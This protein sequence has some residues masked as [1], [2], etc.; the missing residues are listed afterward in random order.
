MELDRLDWWLARLETEIDTD[1][2]RA[3]PVAVKV[4]ERRARLLGL[5][6]PVRVEGTIQQVTAED[7]AL[8]ELIAEAQAAAAVAERGIR[9]QW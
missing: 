1:P 4:S 5:D 8:H 7:V 6:E 9:A 3:I 2:I